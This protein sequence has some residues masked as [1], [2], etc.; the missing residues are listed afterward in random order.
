MRGTGGAARHPRGIDIKR[1]R[2]HNFC[3]G[4][5][6]VTACSGTPASVNGRERALSGFCRGEGLSVSRCPG[7]LS[8]PKQGF[9]GWWGWGL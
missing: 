9:P 2:K 8:C 3:E 5:L 1:F 7:V 6:L 4:G